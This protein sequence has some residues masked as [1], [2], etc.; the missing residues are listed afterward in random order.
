VAEPLGGPVQPPTAEDRCPYPRPFDWHFSACPA[1]MPRLHLATDIRGRPL[2]AHW[3]CAHLVSGRHQAGGYY[4]SCVIGS[5][6]DREHWAGSL[7]DERLTAIRLAR[8]ELSQAIRPALEQ[9]RGAIGNPQDGYDSR[10]RVEARTAWGAL[11]TAFE[12]FV[13]A[14]PDLF[15]AA[16][17]DPKQLQQCF[18]DATAEFTTRPPGRRWEMSEAIVARY[19]WAIQAFFRP[20]LL[21]S[22]PNRPG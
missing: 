9:V 14:H 15:T 12:T 10:R 3:T 8:V 18:S 6:A 13:G 20:D 17:I 1:F 22:P 19:P 11:V 5:A 7:K 16:G 21:Q 2:N 4:P